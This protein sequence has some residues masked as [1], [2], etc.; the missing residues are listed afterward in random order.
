MGDVRGYFFGP[1]HGTTPASVHVT[2]NNQRTNNPVN[3]SCKRSPDTW[4]TW[5]KHNKNIDCAIKSIKV[6]Q[7]LIKLWRSEDPNAKFHIPR[8]MTLWCRGRALE[9]F[10]QYTLN[11]SSKPPKVLVIPRNRRLRLN[12]TEKLFT[13]MLNHNKKKKKKKKKKF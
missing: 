2:T 4:Y 5:Y 8:S 11:K 13:G 7:P 6:R 12:M 10:L 3:W 9:G 1:P